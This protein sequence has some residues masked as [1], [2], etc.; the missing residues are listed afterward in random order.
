VDRDGDVDN[1]ATA[2]A[3]ANGLPAV[4]HNA[5]DGR[6]A[7]AHTAHSSTASLRP[8]VFRKAEHK[9]LIDF[10]ETPGPIAYS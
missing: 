9:I 3:S 6:C 4:A 7:P 2:C 5:L 1:R 8:S 10:F